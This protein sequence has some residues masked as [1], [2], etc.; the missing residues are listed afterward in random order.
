M[1]L[2][3]RQTRSM[4]RKPAAAPVIE[5]VIPDPDPEAGEEALVAVYTLLIDYIIEDRAQEIVDT[6]AVA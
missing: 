3:E 6:S 2:A 1:S 4:P 5:E